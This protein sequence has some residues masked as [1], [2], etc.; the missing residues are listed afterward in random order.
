MDEEPTKALR[1]KKDSSM[2]VAIN[3]VKKWHCW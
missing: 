1:K 2:R 3:L